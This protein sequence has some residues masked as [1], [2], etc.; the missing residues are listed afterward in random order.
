MVRRF[1]DDL[2]E[3][4]APVWEA[5]HHH[6]FVRGIGDGTLSLDQFKFW[7]MQD[8]LYLI[9]YSRLLAIAAARSPDLETMT[10]FSGLLH[11]TLVTEMELHRCYVAEFGITADELEAVPM[12]P[13]TQGYTD[14]LLRMAE[15]GDYAELIAALLPCMWGFA[16]I[17]ERLARGRRPADPRYGRWIDMYSSAEF[18]RLAAWCR[19]VMDRVAADLGPEGRS[20][21]A[22]A[23]L[24]SSRYELAFWEMGWRCEQW[25]V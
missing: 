18:T 22:A 23:F 2:R 10:R 19:E 13:V 6:P 21:A 15:L 12:A 7:I 24:T 20:R 1:S 4:A 17:G 11:E 25:S 9:E 14:F 8:Y 5:Q 3:Q 16:E